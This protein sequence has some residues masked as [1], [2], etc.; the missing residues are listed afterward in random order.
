MA[1]VRYERL[2]TRHA[3]RH[4]GG[5]VEICNG[6]MGKVDANGDMGRCPIPRGATSMIRHY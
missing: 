1:V 6:A 5:A 2:A 3:L 4:A